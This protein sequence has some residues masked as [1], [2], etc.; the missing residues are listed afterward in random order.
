MTKNELYV[1]EG[2]DRLITVDLGARGVI[3]RLYEAA[4]ELV[5]EPLTLRASKALVSRLK[6]GD[7]V[8]VATGF[9]VPPDFIQETDGPLGAA[10]LSVGLIETL[11][12]RPIIIIEGVSMDIMREVLERIGYSDKII[13]EDYPIDPKDACN[14]AGEI[15][16]KYSPSAFIS[17]E[18]AGRN[19]KGVYH[20]MRGLDVSDY[21]SKI[22]FLLEG[23]KKY[24]AL[25]IAV[26]DGGNEVGMGNIRDTIVKY[27]PYGDRCQCPCGA[28]IAAESKVDILVA[29]AVSNWGAYGIEAMLAYL[30]DAKNALHTPDI[31][32]EILR[33]SVDAGAVD[34]VS[35]EM[36]MY[37]DGIEVKYHREVVD[38][39]NKMIRVII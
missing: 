2:I 33:A 23:V 18:K 4:R 32:E 26:G 14:K 37:V 11:K 22:E 12:V 17:I 9:R 3:Y 7:Y 25:T 38:L 20:N 8:V 5:K 16:E 36:K 39:L 21:Q 29:S 6:K 1:G 28:G 35:G 27:V 24:N 10:T 34:G 31:E 30:T 19:V 15:I 13:L